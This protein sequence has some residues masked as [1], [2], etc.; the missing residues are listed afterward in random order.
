M[1]RLYVTEKAKVKIHIRQVHTKEW[2]WECQLCEDQFNIWW[3]CIQPGEMNK[4]KAKKHPVEWEEEQETFRKDHPFIC[5][6]KKCGNRF[7]T[8][9]E[10]DRHQKK[11][12]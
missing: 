10:V 12:H 11:M 1:A 9:V 3:G 8:K 4:H 6:Y 2:S 7:A 5:K